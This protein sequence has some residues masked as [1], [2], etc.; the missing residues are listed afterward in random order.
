MKLTYSLTN[1]SEDDEDEDEDEDATSSRITTVLCALT[2]GKVIYRYCQNMCVLSS[3]LD[4]ADCCG[5]RT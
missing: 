3:L 4:R 5:S 2:P 1:T